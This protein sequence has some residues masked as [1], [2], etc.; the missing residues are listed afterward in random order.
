[1]GSL[2]GRYGVAMGSLWGRYGVA[3][4]PYKDRRLAWFGEDGQCK[5]GDGVPISGSAREG[6]RM[7]GRAA[8]RKIEREG[9]VWRA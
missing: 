1:M 6:Q 4:G 2:W 7:G 9:V 8:G 5:G 3:M